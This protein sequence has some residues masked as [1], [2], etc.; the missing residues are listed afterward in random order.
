[1]IHLPEPSAALMALAIL[2]LVWSAGVAVLRMLFSERTAPP[3]DQQEKTTLAV[4]LA[5]I[6]VGALLLMVAGYLPRTAS[7]PLPL[8]DDFHLPFAGGAAPTTS[9]TPA[10]SFDLLAFAPGIVVTLY[11][12]GAAIAITRLTRASLRMNRTVRTAR[13]AA[14]QG[15]LDISIAQTDLPP[16]ASTTSRII[17]PATLVAHAPQPHIDLIIAHE[18]AHIRRGDPRYYLIL[19]WIEALLWFNPF[20]RAQTAR[21]R[22]AAELAC[23]TAVV[24]AAPEM[25]RTY[26]QA[27]VSALKHA[28][29]DAL[30][31]APAAFSTR[32]HGE[33]R[34][35][36]ANI[37]QAAA[38]PRKQRTAFTIAA[39]IAA[40]PLAC[41]QLAYAFDAPDETATFSSAM[42][43]GNVSSSYGERTDPFTKEK[44][45]HSGVDIAAAD[46]TT[47]NAPAAGT[48][49]RYELALEGYGNMLEIDHGG[50]YVTR[51]G[52]L[53]SASVS[54]GDKV[55]AGQ[56]IAEV[57]SS[58]RATGPHLHVEVY[59]DGETIDP[60]GVLILPAK[61]D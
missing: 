37:M 34:M 36:I 21:C 42:L 40:A 47:I 60:A 20:I 17:L 51:Y 11:L 56:K 22:L 2:P 58:G 14:D 48:V 49:T 13:P 54:A 41:A 16:F 6:A 12:A 43:D 61:K 1:M 27:I 25:R 32:K 30:P 26:A 24:G 38:P 19:S 57:G 29:G 50:G 7:L 45:F 33:Y 15:S 46:G 18:R 3:E 35:R 39:L 44:R 5:P 9:A 23:D 59:R 52:Q 4:M 28:A 31:C 10:N 8:P 53:K 55:N